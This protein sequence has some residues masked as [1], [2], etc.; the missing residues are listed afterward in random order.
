MNALATIEPEAIA[1]ALPGAIALRTNRDSAMKVTARGSVCTTSPSLTTT[2][3]KRAM[4]ATPI[5]SP[6]VL[7]QLLRYEPETGKLFWL[8][9]PGDLFPTLGAARCWNTRYADKEAFTAVSCGYRHGSIFTK[10]Y[11]AHRVGW[12]LTHGVWPD[13]EIDHINGNRCDNRLEN[14]RD[15]TVLENRRNQSR[16]SKNTSGVTGVHWCNTWRRWIAKVMV[17]KKSTTIGSYATF[18]EA[19]AA[20]AKANLKIGFFPGHGKERVG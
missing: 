20:R 4:A 15:V 18:E 1:L 11:R 17:G 13:G 10:Y 9:R 14:L 5:L 7:R 8:R 19:V 3:R 16:S 12:A 6:D 2:R